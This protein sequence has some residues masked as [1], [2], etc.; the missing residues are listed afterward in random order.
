LDKLE[1]DKEKYARLL[2]EHLTKHRLLPSTGQELQTHLKN[3]AKREIRQQHATTE[4]TTNRVVA[5]Q[6]KSDKVRHEVVIATHPAITLVRE[7]AL[8]ARAPEEVAKSSKSSI[9]WSICLAMCAL[10]GVVNNFISFRFIWMW[11]E[12]AAVY[13]FSSDEQATR[14]FCLAIATCDRTFRYASNG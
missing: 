4:A 11:E 9:A 3:R 10:P 8:Q 13:I 1:P 7:E 12:R 5:A 2:T 14:H 6:T